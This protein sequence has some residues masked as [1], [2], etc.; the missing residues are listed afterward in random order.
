[1]TSLDAA[2]A[3]KVTAGAGSKTGSGWRLAVSSEALKRIPG[4]G[5]KRAQLHFFTNR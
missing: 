1:M 3:E 4:V 2:R 5:W